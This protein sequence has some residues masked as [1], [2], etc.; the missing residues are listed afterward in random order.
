MALPKGYLDSG[1]FAL[2]GNDDVII[3]VEIYDSGKAIATEKPEET[4]TPDSSAQPSGKPSAEPAQPSSSTDPGNAA[5]QTGSGAASTPAPENSGGIVGGNDSQKTVKV[6]SKPAKVKIKKASPLKR[7][8]VKVTWKKVTGA[9]WY[10]IQYS[11]KRS[12]SGSKVGI[13]YGKKTTLRLKKKKT[14]YIRILACKYGNS[15]NNYRA[16]KGK[17]SKVKKVK[18]KA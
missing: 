17:W 15:A 7:G 4:K 18:T 6:P 5:D 8:K 1:Y 11:T 12:F 9:D 3:K 16:V 2:F 14:Y 13:V 10:I